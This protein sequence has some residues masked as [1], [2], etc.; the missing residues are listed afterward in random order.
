MINTRAEGQLVILVLLIFPM[1]FF[2]GQPPSV[3]MPPHPPGWNSL[4]IVGH[5]PMLREYCEAGEPA[6]AMIKAFNMCDGDMMSLYIP[7]MSEKGLYFT[8]NADYAGIVSTDLEHWGK[9]THKDRRGLFYMARQVIG[10]SLFVASDTEVS[11]S[12][13]SFQFIFDPPPLSVN[14]L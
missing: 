9:I 5:L 3:V 6:P 11:F 12:L 2:S 10:D 1:I 8:D 4:P 13:S 14:T 7:G